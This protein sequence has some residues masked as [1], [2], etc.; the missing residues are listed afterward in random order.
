MQKQEESERMHRREMQLK[1]EMEI[2]LQERMMENSRLHQEASAQRMEECR[3]QMEQLHNNLVWMTAA[4]GEERIQELM[5]NPVLQEEVN[6]Q[7]QVLRRNMEDMQRAADPPDQDM[8]SGLG[9]WD[10]C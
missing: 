4:A 6:Q 3:L 1:R 5:S 8:E 2:Q 10:Q 7:A 9:S